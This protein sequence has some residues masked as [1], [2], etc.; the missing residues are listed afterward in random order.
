MKWSYQDLFADD[1]RSFSEKKHFYDG[2]VTSHDT[3][4]P[5]NDKPDGLLALETTIRLKTQN[6][7]KIKNHEKLNHI[8]IRSGTY[9]RNCIR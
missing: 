1:K 5:G 7:L 6:S 2:F 9:G 4:L 3:G 8:L